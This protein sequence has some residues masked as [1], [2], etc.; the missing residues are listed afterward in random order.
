MSIA[1]GAYFSMLP[2]FADAGEPPMWPSWW[3][4][5]PVGFFVVGFLVTVIPMASKKRAQRDDPVPPEPPGK[6]E[7]PEEPQRPRPSIEIGGPGVRVGR[8]SISDSYSNNPDGLAGI[9]GAEIQDAQL[10][11]NIHDVPP[12]PPADQEGDDED[13]DSTDN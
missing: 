7:H 5:I 1:A 3:L 6:P 2:I 4:A 11:R 9:F 8:V 10:E 12:R 13:Q